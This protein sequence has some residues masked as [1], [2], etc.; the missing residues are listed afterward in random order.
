[1]AVLT[2]A[3]TNETLVLTGVS[4]SYNSVPVSSSPSNKKYYNG[5]GVPMVFSNRIFETSAK[6]EINN[7]TRTQYQ[8]ILDFV[9]NKIKFQLNPFT[10]NVNTLNLGGGG[11]NMPVQNCRMSSQDTDGFSKPKPPGFYDVFFAFT[12]KQGVW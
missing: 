12:F 4:L 8:Q 2:I 7:L 3:T 9:V 6:L 10:V 11:I 5:L 1:M